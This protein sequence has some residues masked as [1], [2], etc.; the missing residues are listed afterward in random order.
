MSHW[1][2][3]LIGLG[4]SFIGN[5]LLMGIPGGVLVSIVLPIMEGFGIAK[6]HS[7]KMWPAAIATTFLWGLLL[8]PCYWLNHWLGWHEV[9]AWLMWFVAGLAV[10]AIVCGIM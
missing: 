6:F 2:Y 10:A 7:D 8:W 5:M 1:M 4:V 3:L 9:I